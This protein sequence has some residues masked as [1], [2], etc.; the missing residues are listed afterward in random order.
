MTKGSRDHL[1]SEAF[2]PIK[3]GSCM[4]PDIVVLQISQMDIFEEKRGLSDSDRT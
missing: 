3:G 4:P 1:E 2:R